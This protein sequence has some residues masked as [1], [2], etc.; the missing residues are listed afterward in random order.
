LF[1]FRIKPAKKPPLEFSVAIAICPILRPGI[2]RTP[3][4]L[5]AIAILSSF[6]G[7]AVSITRTINALVAVRACC[8]VAKAQT[9]EE[10]EE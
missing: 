2:R 7:A 4:T 1:A 8:T 9:R 3:Q 10:N 6:P 5:G